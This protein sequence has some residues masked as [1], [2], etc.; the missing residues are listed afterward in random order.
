MDKR[1]LISCASAAMLIAGLLACSSAIVPCEPRGDE[2]CDGIDDDCDGQTD[3]GFSLGEACD[4]DDADSCANGTT[5]CTSDGSGTQCVNEDPTDLTESCNNADDD[6]DGET[7]EGLTSC[8]CTGG[9]APGSET[10]NNVDDN[11][12]GQIDDGISN[13]G[14]SDG[15]P[16]AEICNGIDDDC[17]EQADE[18]FGTGLPCDGDDD[19][20]CVNGTTTC[21]SDGSG[22]ECVNEDPVNL[23]ESCNNADDDCD[24]D[25]D[26]GLTNCGCTGGNAPAGETCN[27]ID[28][29]CDGQADDGLTGCGCTGGNPPVAET[30]NNT[31]DDCNGQVDDGLTGCGCTGGN[32]PTAETCNNTD[33]DCNGQVDDGLADCQCS[34]GNPPAAETCNNTDD[35]CNG[36]VDDGLA[37]CQCSGGNPPAAEVCDGIDNDCDEQIDEDSGS[38]TACAGFGEPCNSYLD[39]T[40]RICAG[41]SFERYC[42]AECDA[43]SDPATWPAGYR[44]VVGPS[45]DYY[46]RDYA[47]CGS[48]ADCAPDGVCTYREADDQLSIVTECRPPHDP[49]AAPGDDCSASTCAN[50]LCSWYTDLCTEI[51]SAPGDC[52]TQY[53][54][55]HNNACVF[56]WEVVSPGDCGRDEQCPAG[57]SCQSAQC[58]GPTCTDDGQCQAGYACSQI[59]PPD[60]E[61]A[62]QP[63]PFFDFIGECRIACA[64]DPDCP[65]GMQCHPAVLVDSSSVQGFCRV[66]PTGNTIPT[67]GGPCGSG[68]DPCSHG[69]CYGSGASSFCTQLCGLASDCPGGVM[70][71]TAGT[72]NMGSLGSFPGTLT[73]TNP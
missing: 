64:G 55:P 68:Y 57:Y 14:C 33:D 26:E 2:I 49:G 48:D 72:L 46:A 36:Q 32:P 62:C 13:C 53:L 63:K 31:D 65:S 52:S 70:N 34:G 41:D 20:Q 28:D 51:C 56:A 73:C 3:E 25:T 69:I 5:T 50:G 8:A 17:D 39:C 35:D 58:L 45:K 22:T 42:S 6:C 15:S 1:A 29:D 12:N 23:T 11:C 9:N 21:T 37:D 30:C 47:V 54:P 18:D 27:N 7:D 66:P 38:G 71:C 44:C 40:G 67:G 61:K 4:G 24:G 10:C 60:P 16:A 19:D 59:N 43:A